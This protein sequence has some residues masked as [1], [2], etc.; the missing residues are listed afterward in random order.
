MPAIA[1]KY[2]RLEMGVVLDTNSLDASDAASV[3]LRQE[4]DGGWS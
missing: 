4:A 2:N 1:E 3:S